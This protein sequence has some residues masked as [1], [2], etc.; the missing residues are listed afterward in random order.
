MKNLKE[1]LFKDQINEGFKLGKNK[2]KKEDDYFVDL[3]LP[4][5]ALWCKYN[6]GATCESDA[7]SWYGNYFTWGD[8]EPANNKMCNWENYKYVNGSKKTLTKYCPDDKIDYWCDKGNP[9]NKLVL[10]KE[11][12]MVNANMGYDWK[13]PTNEQLQELIDNTTSEW[14]KNYN[15]IQGLNGRLFISNTNDNELFM[16]AAGYQ[17]G[18]VVYD[19]GSD[20]YV[21]SSMLYVDNPSYAYILSADMYRTYGYSYDFRY[22]GFSIRGIIN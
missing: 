21:W 15:D 5:G 11:D 6:V 16:P 8:I 9:D 12:D 14:V 10:D 17:R 19:V 7:K 22:H 20:I 2:V 4:S 1:Y 3:D 18:S 13:M